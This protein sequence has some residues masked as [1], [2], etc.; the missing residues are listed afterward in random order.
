MVW[1][2]FSEAQQVGCQQDGKFVQWC[3]AECVI[4]CHVYEVGVYTV[5]LYRSVVLCC[6]VHKDQGSCSK[7]SRTSIPSRSGKVPHR[8]THKVSFPV[9]TQSAG[10]I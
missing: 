8:A 9:E 6:T 3:G 1:P 7:N 5:T 2:A 10:G 4:K